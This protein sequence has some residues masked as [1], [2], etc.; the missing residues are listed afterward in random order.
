MLRSM[1]GREFRAAMAGGHP[2]GIEPLQVHAKAG[3]VV[4]AHPLL[5]HDIA[6]NQSDLVRWAVLFR[7]HAVKTWAERQKLLS[8]PP[9]ELADLGPEQSLRCF[10]SGAPIN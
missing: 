3:D 1:S 9:D 4:F 7:P 2:L 5:A 10:S 6:T 8:P